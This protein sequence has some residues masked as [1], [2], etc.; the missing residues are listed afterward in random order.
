MCHIH[1]HTLIV[2][3]DEIITKLQICCPPIESW[4][5]IKIIFMLIREIEFLSFGFH[6]NN[7]RRTHWANWSIR[8]THSFIKIAKWQKYLKVI[9]NYHLYLSIATGFASWCKY[10][11]SWYTYTYMCVLHVCQPLLNFST[12][13]DLYILFDV[14]I[15]KVTK[16]WKLL[17]V[18]G[19]SMWQ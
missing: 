17:N 14:N 15:K 12:Q 4:N 18:H 9:F 2:W 11:S 19:T 16:N 7:L 5:K 3:S 13:K 6:P 10:I 1:H 8:R